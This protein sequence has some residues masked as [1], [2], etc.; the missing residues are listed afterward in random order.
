MTTEHFVKARPAESGFIPELEGM[1]ALAVLAVLL[2]HL[3]ITAIPGGYL[4]VD[5]FFVISGFIISRNLIHDVRGDGLKLGNFYLRRF[6]RIIPALA[7]TILCTL[8][9]GWYLLPPDQLADTSLAAAYSLLSVGNFH[10]WLQAGYFAPAAQVQPLLHT[11]SLGVEEQFYLFWPA[12]LLL[13]SRRLPW[14]VSGLLLASAA[15]ALAMPADQSH[16]VFYMLPF[17]VHQF[18]AGALAALFLLRL[19]ES[20]KTA[21]SLAAC[22]AFLALV[23]TCD[24]GSSA[25]VTAL[26]V[27]I[28]GLLM[29]AC[30]GNVFSRAVFGNRLMLWVGRRSYALYLAHWPVIVYYQYHNNFVA[31]GPWEQFGLAVAALIAAIALHTLVEKPFRYSARSAGTWQRLAAPATATLVVTGVALSMLWWRQDGVPGRFSA[32]QQDIELQASTAREERRDAIRMGRCNLK[33][34]SAVQEYDPAQ[35]SSVEPG[36]RNVLVVGDSLAADTYMMLAS[37]YPEIHFLQAT[38]SGCQPLLDLR[39]SKYANC[40]QLNQLRLNKLA[41]QPLDLVVLAATWKESNLPKLV[42]TVAHLRS[43]GNAIAVAGPRISFPSKVPLLLHS[44]RDKPDPN[45]A[46]ADLADRH[47]ELLQDMRA[48]LPGVPVIDLAAIQCPAYCDVMLQGRL[49]YIDRHHFSPAGAQLMGQRL[50]ASV[51]LFALMSSPGG[52]AE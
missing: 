18:M 16:S 41:F 4:G 33:D 29:I 13:C 45:H 17:R 7:V 31:P 10:F 14:L 52:A 27:S 8:A 11:W 39:D 36:K 43:S 49:L 20:L 34:R 24:E 26:S 42:E 9:A 3:G 37:A 28:V 19:P 23:A 6:R 5:L 32:D 46:V 22:L 15:A 30:Q 38:A 48:A 1:R 12:L 51:D 35:C 2:F 40:L 50:R 21:A 44:A 47:L 25:A